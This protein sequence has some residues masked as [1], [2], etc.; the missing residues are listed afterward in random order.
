MA[1]VLERASYSYLRRG[2]PVGAIALLT[3]AADLSPGVDLRGRRLAEAAYLGADVTG[4]LRDLSTL[5]AQVDDPSSDRSSLPV[6]IAAAYALLNGD[7][8]IGTAHRLLIGAI[9]RALDGTPRD[10]AALSEALYVLMLACFFGGRAVLWPPFHAAIG[11]S[12]D[13]LAVM[14]RVASRTFP[15]PVRV[16]PDALAELDHLVDGLRDEP[17][18]THIVRAGIASFYVDRLGSCRSALWRIVEDGRAGGAVASGINAL[19]LLAFD[20][21]LTGNWIEADALAA[22]AVALCDEKGYVLLGWPARLGRAVI[23]AA[24]GDSATASAIAD[25]MSRWATPRAVTKVQ[26]YAHQVRSLD[27][28]GRA[29][30]ESAYRHA[31]ALSPA[32][33]LA[34]HVGHALWVILDVVEAAIRTGRKAEAAAHAMALASADVARIS[35]RMAL[36]SHGAQAIVEGDDARSYELFEEAL[37]G[38]PHESLFE[39]ARIQLAYGERL[40]RGRAMTA[41]RVQLK[42]ALQTFERLGATPWVLRASA[43]LRGTGQRRRVGTLAAD[44]LTPQEREIALLAAAGLSNRE[45]GARVY[46]SHRTVGAHLYRVFP[47]LGITS[48][49]ALRD[50]LGHDGNGHELR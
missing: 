7:G 36:V 3:R 30:Y 29:D 4:D 46:L 50:A 34:S 49:A 23:A 47:K 15:D 25:E 9:D 8:D 21:L 16:A 11:R 1:G 27:A 28:I 39:A 40:R 2:D 6:A 14:L 32:G 43:E 26:M 18:P 41:A 31:V 45:I 12:G 13:D 33:V 17:D 10:S 48:R 20:D 38:R 42:A 24:R 22:E 5:L 19:V 37:A 35:P 44:A